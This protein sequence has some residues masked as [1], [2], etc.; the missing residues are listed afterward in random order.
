MMLSASAPRRVYPRAGSLVLMIAGKWFGPKAGAKTKVDPETKVNTE[1]LKAAGGVDR[2]KV[3][4]HLG[5]PAEFSE[6]WTTK[7]VVFQ[8]RAPKADGSPAAE[9]P[10]AETG[11]PAAPAGA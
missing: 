4:Q 1:V 6:T 10:A 2:I 3:T 9:A 11:E 7:Q 8:K 5:T